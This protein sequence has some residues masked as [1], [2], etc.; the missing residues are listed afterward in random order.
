M[1][2]SVTS[3]NLVRQ[4]LASALLSPSRSDGIHFAL[5]R[6]MMTLMSAEL[7]AKLALVALETGDLDEAVSCLRDALDAAQA[8]QRPFI[9]TA[10]EIPACGI[11]VI[12]G[13][14]DL[15]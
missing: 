3:D 7:L 11:R 15:S 6:R 14:V 10:D 1:T 12:L 8:T 5:S 13:T 2:L 9:F 4:F